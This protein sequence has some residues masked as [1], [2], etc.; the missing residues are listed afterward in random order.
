ML[1]N[2]VTIELARTGVVAAGA[3][4]D[5]VVTTAGVSGDVGR[6]VR[7]RCGVLTTVVCP[8]PAP[9]P[10]VAAA[11]RVAGPLAAGLVGSKRVVVVVTVVVV[12]VSLTDGLSATFWR[13]GRRTPGGKLA[14]ER[15]GPERGAGHPTQETH[16]DKSESV[17]VARASHGRSRRDARSEANKE[18]REGEGKVD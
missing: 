9:A 13:W 5:R 18:K 14:G 7:L 11:V 1:T 8:A 4:T 15:E 10:P 12:V 2:E 3:T 17:S 6:V 16:L